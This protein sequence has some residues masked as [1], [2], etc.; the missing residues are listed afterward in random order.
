MATDETNL[1][2]DELR[3]Y[4]RHLSLAEIGI[5]GQQK[6]KAARVL[7]IGTGGLGSPAAMY[8]AAAGMGTLGLV[9]FDTVDES[10]L[11][12]QIL[13][14][15]ADVGRHKLD[16]AQDT[17]HSVNP[18]VALELHHDRLS[19]ANAAE[20]ISQYDLVL[21]GTDNFATRYLVNDACVILGK[22]NCYGS[23]L[24]FQGQASV[25]A[26]PDGPCYRCLYPEPPPA[27]E[28]PSCADAGVLGILPGVIGLIQATEAIK[29]VVG[30]GDSLV[31][32]V[33][34]YDAMAMSFRDL[35]LHRDP[36]CPVCGDSP[37]IT[38]IQEIAV[39]CAAAPDE[40][41]DITSSELH[42]MQDRRDDY[43]LLDV[44][45]PYEH[46]VAEIPGNTLIP[47]GE[48]GGRLSEIPADRPIVVY[49]HSGFRSAQTV[50]LLTKEGYE[51][52]ANLVGGIQRWQAEA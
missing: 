50:E 25:F 49:C 41:V 47:M 19:A 21:D 42:K 7:L 16:S 39:V 33:L 15:T 11:Q 36:A 6:L 9:D 28:I 10:N 20:I 43:F 8:L 4:S 12:R 24:R 51:N 38:S 3:R 18:H 35:R 23:V 34:L 5:D 40:V 2:Q 31:G 45:E 37:T 17:L 44:R 46:A 14:G 22:P 26:H 1:T 30:K 29:L 52:V 48:V 13:H 32:R 27:D